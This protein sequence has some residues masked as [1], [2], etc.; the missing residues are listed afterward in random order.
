MQ[1]LRIKAAPLP[2]PPILHI[3]L[4]RLSNQMWAGAVPELLWE[5]QGS[6]AARLPWSLQ[7][8]H[9]VLVFPEEA[10]G[11]STPATEQQSTAPRVQL[12]L[13]V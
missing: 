2:L 5:G 1:V 10:P 8:T 13:N 4:H 9:C 7:S 11:G 6:L 12:P 3:G